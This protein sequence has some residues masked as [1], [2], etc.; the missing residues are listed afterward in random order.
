MHDKGFFISIEGVDGSGKSTLINK[1]EQALT[2]ISRNV[3]ITKE[4]GG[5]MLGEMLRNILQKSPEKLDGKA[6]FLLFAADRA[7]HFARVIIPALQKGTF[8]ISDRGADSSLAY[9]GYG[10]NVNLS[11]IK[12]INSW[13]MQN[14]VPSITFYL[15]VDVETATQRLLANREEL[16]TFEKEK[17]D[18]WKRVINGYEEIFAKRPNAIVLEALHDPDVLFTQAWNHLS[19]IVKPLQQEV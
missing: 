6:E 10:H 15:R 18:F 14:T 3:L 16:T 5:S 4:P 11:I 8:I 7:Q 1:L 9:Q 13:I 19:S 2:E 12:L 17:I